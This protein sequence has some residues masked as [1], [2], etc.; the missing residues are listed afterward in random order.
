MGWIKTIII[1]KNCCDKNECASKAY[2]FIS[3]NTNY[4]KEAMLESWQNQ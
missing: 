3:S 2:A 1:G 4:K